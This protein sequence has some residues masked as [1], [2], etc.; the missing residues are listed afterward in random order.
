MQLLMLLRFRELAFGL[1]VRAVFMVRKV[2]VRTVRR[3][4]TVKVLNID[5]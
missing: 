3:A 1:F 5:E 2:E 4:V